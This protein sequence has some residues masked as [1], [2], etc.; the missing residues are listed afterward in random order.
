MIYYSQKNKKEIDS[1]CL[2]GNSAMQ[3]TQGYSLQEVL[4]T[5]QES[6]TVNIEF[7]NQWEKVFQSEG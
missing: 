7:Y 3:K 5:K 4:K 2:I 6:K 1:R